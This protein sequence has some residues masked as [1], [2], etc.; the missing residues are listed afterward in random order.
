MHRGG[1][2][3]VP[4][5]ALDRRHDLGHPRPE[6]S[7]LRSPA[8]PDEL[9]EPLRLTIRADARTPHRRRYASSPA[10]SRADARHS[11]GSATVRRA[12]LVPAYPSRFATS[13]TG[14]QWVPSDAVSLRR[15]SPVAAYT[16][17]SMSIAS[18]DHHLR[19]AS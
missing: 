17:S 16:T 13:T 15:R 1:F 6:R 19:L 7:G 18:I 12:S 8:G 3:P 9:D 10:T 2:E 11:S 5:V 4:A 14:N